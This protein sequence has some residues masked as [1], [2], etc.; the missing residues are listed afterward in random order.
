LL[1]DERG[2]GEPARNTAVRGLDPH[3][4]RA[5]RERAKLFGKWILKGQ[6]HIK[7]T[8]DFRKEPPTK[9]TITLVILVT[10]KTTRE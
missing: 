6:Q 10:A 4:K 3:S 2:R 5:G 7:K 9:T 1:N 8:K